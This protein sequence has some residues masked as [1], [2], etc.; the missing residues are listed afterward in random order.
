MKSRVI[1]YSLIFTCA[2]GFLALMQEHLFIGATENSITIEQE[3]VQQFEQARKH[4][5]VTSALLLLKLLVDDAVR[6]GEKAPDYNL[7]EFKVRR[8]PHLFCENNRGIARIDMPQMSGRPI[9]GTPAAA[10]PRNK[11]GEVDGTNYFENYLRKNKNYT[12]TEEVVPLANLKATQKELVGSK[13]AGIWL[14]MQDP[15]SPTYKEI[16]EGYFFISKDNYILDGHHRWAAFV[17]RAISEGN[18]N[19]AKVRVK[20]VNI[21]IDQLI[22][23]ANKFTNDFGIEVEAGLTAN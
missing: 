12:I 16:T 17:A 21:G 1:R 10:L 13:V 11:R 3:L 8:F 4:G 20:R 14:A 22:K 23:D 6:K 7:C 19:A 9:P 5:D 2:F 15:N 18:L